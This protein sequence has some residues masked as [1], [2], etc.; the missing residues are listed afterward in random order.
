MRSVTEAI[1][2]FDSR[3]EVETEHGYLDK[4]KEKETVLTVTTVLNP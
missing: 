2:G 4:E 1:F 3:L